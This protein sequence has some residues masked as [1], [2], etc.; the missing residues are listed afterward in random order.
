MEFGTEWDL[1][2]I[3]TFNKQGEC[4]AKNP[5]SGRRR[6]DHRAECCQGF[7]EEV[8]TKRK[9]WVPVDGAYSRVVGVGSQDCSTLRS[10]HGKSKSGETFFEKDWKKIAFRV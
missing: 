4:L 8:L 2:G 9:T 6:S 3:A 7:S 1:W 10:E 5:T